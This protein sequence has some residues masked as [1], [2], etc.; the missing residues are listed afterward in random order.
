MNRRD[1]RPPVLIITAVVI[2]LLIAN[3]PVDG[4]P[5]PPDSP[6]LYCELIDRWAAEYQ[7]DPHLVAAVI[8]NESAFDPDR[9]SPE[10]AVGLMQ[11][12]PSTAEMSAGNLQMSGFTPDS[13]WDPAINIQLGTHYL[14]TLLEQFAGDAVAALAA[15]NAGPGRVYEW[16]QMERWQTQSGIDRIPLMETRSY[17]MLVLEDYERYRQSSPGVSTQQE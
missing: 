8:E 4:E 3:I 16:Q 7:V 9:L 12:L 14:A 11:I 2:T 6:Y 1:L 13:L 17:V 5:E 15:Y 10:G